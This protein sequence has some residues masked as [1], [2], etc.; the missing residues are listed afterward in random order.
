MKKSGEKRILSKKKDFYS[1]DYQN[2]KF[3]LNSDF[4]PTGDQPEAINRLVEGINRGDHEQTLMGVTGSGKTFTMANVIELVQ[5][6]TLVI[7]QNKTLAGQLTEEF[8]TFF[9]NNAVE[10]FVSYYDYYQPE[11]YIPGTDTYI[12]KDS[13]INDEIDRMRHSATASLL[14]RRDVIV[15]ASVSCIYGLG[16]PEDYSE[17]MLHLRSGMR[18]DRDELIAE[19]VRLQYSRN[20]YELL[21]GTF[22]VKGD[23]VD[24]HPVNYENTFLRVSFFGD[25]IDQMLEMDRLSNK[26]LLARHY[27]SI[28]PAS[29]Y[30]T[31]EATTQKAIKRIEA[32]LE[33]RLTE[34]RDEGKIVEA[35]RL[36][37][38]T[39]YDIEML[40]ET[41]FVKG[42]ENYSRHFS[43]RKAGDPPNTLID[44]FPDDFLL[45][46]DESH[47]TIPQIGGMAAGDRSRKNSLVD[48]GFRL[49]SAY[50]NRPL[51]AE[52]FFPKI[53]QAIYVSAT[54]GKYE[55]AHSSQMVEQIIRPTGLVDPEISIRPISGQ[56]EDLLGEIKATIARGERALIMTLTK[57][58][59]EDFTDFLQENGIKVQYL[60]SDV[61]N[62]ERLAIL[63]N[64]R[65]GKIDVIVGINLL[66]EGL[67]LP[68]VSLIAILDA[69]KEGFLRSTTSLI[70]IIGRAARN[71]N[72]KVIMYG[73]KITDSMF[74]AVQETN[75]RR[76]IQ[77]AYNKE[78]NITPQTIK[79]EIKNTLDTFEEIVNTE[80][81][82]VDIEIGKD[83]DSMQDKIDKMPFADLQKLIDRLEDE[84][85]Q[86][87]AALEFE[88]A[89]E[90]RDLL[91]YARG[92]MARK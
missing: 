23:T 28:T 77:E 80:D 41:G 37:Q 22:R 73:D 12:E 74:A 65:S 64:L 30:A 63:R 18:I 88:N 66:R 34:L 1:K 71:V 60:H 11:A 76:E 16:N 79:K 39:R 51:T 70:Q 27:E 72:G 86:A 45:M 61:V 57:R 31:T 52:E 48:F 35:Y 59:A 46:I 89:A 19:L 25:E 47:V 4:K 90:L 50:D 68:E 69:D 78:H 92:A 49:P 10:Y 43:E 6:P 13:S 56:I 81:L 20:D 7:A 29:H 5:K 67:D 8:R 85:R 15:V 38:R 91:I 58:M 14:E 84:M 53:N 62:D 42:I 83:S 55:R 82:S 54:P 44:F 21:R 26:V 40:E 87:A 9:P 33:D 17:L 32:E 2:N 24:I 36:E 3:V 75:R